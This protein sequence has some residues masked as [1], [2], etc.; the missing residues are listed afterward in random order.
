MAYSN[1]LDGIWQ[2]DYQ[3]IN[4]QT[5][6]QPTLDLSQEFGPNDPVAVARH[7]RTA[8]SH[9]MS[10]WEYQFAVSNPAPLDQVVTAFKGKTLGITPQPRGTIQLKLNAQGM[11]LDVAKSYQLENGESQDLCGP[12]AV[13]ALRLAGLPNHGPQCSAE[14]IDRW[15]DDE[16]N[17]NMLSNQSCWSSTSIQQMYVFMTDATDPHSGQHNIHWWEIPTDAQHITAAVKAGYPVI[18]TANE[19]NII[20]KRTGKR[21]YPWNLN[22]NHILPVLGLDKDSDFICADPLNNSFQ[23]YWPP[24]YHASCI[25]PSWATIVQIVV[26]DPAHLWLKPIPS[27]DPGTWPQG[28]IGQNF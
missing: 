16:V 24:V 3:Q 4:R 26:P 13:S 28:F 9:A 18:I 11:V 8:G 10:I 21:A 14:D 27:G 23:G 5:C 15:V 2:N 20:E 12:W 1:A 19:Q 6:L 17:K 25:N 22:V 7:F